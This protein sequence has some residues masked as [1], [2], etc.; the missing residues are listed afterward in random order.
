M[1]AFL[2]AIRFL[3]VIPV[4]GS[5]G[6]RE[7]E[8]ERSVI[9]FPVVGLIS[10]AFLSAIA[11]L[12]GMFMPQMPLAVL[13]IIMLAGV[14]GGFHYDGLSDTADGLLSSRGRVR[15][16]EIMRDSRIGS[17]GAL[18][19]M[20]VFLLKFSALAALPQEHI[21]FALLLMPIAGR[22]AVVFLMSLLPYARAEGGLGTVFY[23]KSFTGA[24][25]FS[26]VLLTAVS[27]LTFGYVG[28]FIV[29]AVIA[30]VLL[31]G[32][33]IFKKLGGSTGDTLGAVCEIAE[34]LPPLLLCL[35]VSAQ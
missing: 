3:T 28:L 2:A 7:Q 20:S 11:V 34:I 16:L 13:L 18:S 23:G 30:V 8:L 26:L 35:M 33:Y 6:T 29:G 17:M 19:I 25:V 12:L 31:F 4:P 24:V 10:G 14:S 21:P 32:Y 5:W 22:S 15:K 27:Y 1:K 9:F